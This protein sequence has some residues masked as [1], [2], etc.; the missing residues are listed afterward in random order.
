[1]K[2]KAGQKIKAKVPFSITPMKIHIEYVL[3]TIYD[4][5]LIVYRVYGKY[6]RW[7]HY[8]T[9]YDFEMDIY[10]KNGQ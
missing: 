8:F 9:C 1:M 7:W 6:K 10:V 5:K 3:D 4:D 2:Y